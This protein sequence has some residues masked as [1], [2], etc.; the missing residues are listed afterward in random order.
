M[1]RLAEY[2]GELAEMLGESTS[3]HFVKLEKSSTSVVHRIEKEAIP[4]I[5]H[6]TRR[7]A[8]GVGARDAV[9]A[10]QKINRMVREDNGRAV[11][12]RNRDDGF[13]ADTIVF[14]GKDEAQQVIVSESR[15]GSVDGEVLR[16][17]GVKKFVPIL[18]RYEDE[19]FSGCYADK[20][21]AKRLAKRL[22]EPVR[23]F[24]VG[25]WNR[26]EEGKWK[27]EKFR[28]SNFNPLK[29]TSAVEAFNILRGLNIGW[30]AE[31]YEKLNDLRAPDPEE[32]NG[33]L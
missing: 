26:D 29:E 20:D 4:K 19:E 18:L 3:V 23:L 15:L 8:R 31:A 28:V 32:A 7:V 21:L 14:P 17:G 25:R 13:P 6:R 12:Q 30:D 1:A 27:L 22:F 11:W 16:V 33:H 10:Y 5:R 2:L 9:R 24:G